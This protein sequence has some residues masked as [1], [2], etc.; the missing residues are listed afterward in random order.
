MRDLKPILSREM[1]HKKKDGSTTTFLTSKI[2]LIDTDGYA[3]GLVGISLDISDRKK[4]ELE[5]QKLIEV[6]SSQ[7]EK[8]IN[9]AHIVSHN[10]RSHTSNFSMLLNFLSQEDS[11]VERQKIMDMLIDSSNN[12]QE[13]LNNLNEVVDINI[14]RD[15]PK[16]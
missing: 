5:L 15:L 2:P 7:N 8:L 14:N 4:K 16:L 6:T 10:L 9:F 1:P 3:Y 13:T 12:L 11:K